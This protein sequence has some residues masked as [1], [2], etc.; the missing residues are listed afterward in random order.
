MSPMHRIL[1]VLLGFLCLA[2]FGY[3]VG[4][5]PYQIEVSLYELRS[6]QT[7]PVIRVA[8]LSDLHLQSLGRREAAIAEQ[9]QQALPDLLILSGDVIDR[10]DTL[11]VLDKFLAKLDTAHKVA[12]LGNWEHW[13]D[14]DFDAL[15]NLYERH[16]VRLLINTRVAYTIRSR[17]IHIAGM[18]DFTA[19]QPDHSLML[20]PTE[21]GTAVLI[22][23]SPGWFEQPDAK[24]YVGHIDLCLS[25]HTH[26]GQVAFMGMPLWTP[27]GS[28]S[29]TAGFYQASSCK[30]YV[31]RG[32]G[33]SILPIRLGSKPEIAIFDL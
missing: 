25:G 6:I 30:L 17:V 11:P 21:A 33:T 18:D 16:E 27:P 15:R 2:V 4:I 3:G 23:H 7:A 29:Y 22:Q 9:L 32:L 19:G 28:G 20:P 8:Q 13:S 1:S 26:G 24:Q 10:P 31:S 12:V 5:A 14:V